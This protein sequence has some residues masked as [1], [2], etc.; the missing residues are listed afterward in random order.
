[1]ASRSAPRSN[2]CDASVCMPSRRAVR[3]IVTGSHHAASRRTFFVSRV[4]AVRVPHDAGEGDRALGV[5]DDDVGG[6]ERALDAVERHELLA[7]RGLAHD[8]PAAG[9]LVEVERVERLAGV[10][11]DVVRRVHRGRDRLAPIAARRRATRGRGRRG[12]PAHERAPKRRQSRGTSITIE[13]SVL[14]GVAPGARAPRSAPPCPAG[15]AGHG[16]DLA[17]E[18]AVAHRVRPVGR[19][20]DLEDRVRRPPET[21]S[22]GMPAWSRSR[23]TPSVP[24]A[25][26]TSTK[27]D[28][29]SSENFTR[30]PRTGA[31]TARR[32]RTAGGGPGTRTSG[33]RPGRCPGRTRSRCT[34]PGRC[35]RPGGRAG[36]PCR[37]P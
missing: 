20:L 14:G 29:P 33:A 37:R 1:M 31:G 27:S 4:T 18:P 22:T 9:E 8:E 21:A 23:R 11:Q 7:A 35:R 24:P 25:A 2:R 6:L 12:D 28:E 32:P 15:L 3:R 30:A 17:R 19:D 34:P 13:A 36:G 5:R 16:G 10:P 26:P